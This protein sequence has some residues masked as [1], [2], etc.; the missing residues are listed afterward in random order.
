MT[1]QSAQFRSTFGFLMAATGF[2]VG[3]GNIWRFPYMTGE[4]GGG[5][6]V[7]VYVLCAFGIGIPILVAEILI[8]RRGGGS[9]P[10]SFGTLSQQEGASSRWRFVGHLNLATAFL[11]MTTY[12]AVA[13]WVLWYLY[14][15]VVTGFAGIDATSAGAEF[16]AMLAS[17][18]GMLFWTVAVLALT[19]IIIYAGVNEGIERSVRL[20]MPTLFLL[21]VSLVVYN[22]FAGGF[23]QAI[24]Y[25]FTPD[26]SKVNGAMLLAAVGQ[27][28]FSIGVAMAGMM[29]FGAYLPRSVS[30]MKVAL[31]VIVADTLVAVL[32]GLM[33]FPIVFRFGLDPA[34]GTGLLFQILPVAFAQ[35]PGGHVIAVLFFLLVTVAAVTSM[36]GLV[37][38]LVAW[39]AE[40]GRFARHRATIAVMGA[41]AILSVISILS[42]NVLAGVRVGAMSIN[43]ATDFLS[44][45]VMLPLGGLL[46]AIFAGWV[47]RDKDLADELGL[48]GVLLGAWHLAIRFVVPFAV[49]V[50]MVT[51]LS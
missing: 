50:I 27:A 44:N 4:N 31:I 22:A 12:S 38:P 7:A 43:G 49:A 36:V 33:I 11:I 6:F 18:G 24:D 19:G 30:I 3:L 15:A 47:I 29:T 42:Y 28:F 26:F 2:A 10:T 8:G 1:G 13:G 9:P 48:S 41:I 16:D 51:G 14:K 34:G 45:Q 39:L 20:L 25:L 32:A 46:I 23:G 17:N 21:I 35:M 5:V 40:R 37:E